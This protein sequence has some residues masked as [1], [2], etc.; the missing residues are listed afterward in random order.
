MNANPQGHNHI[1]KPLMDKFENNSENHIKDN[2]KD[3]TGT[4]CAPNTSIHKWLT[5][6]YKLTENL[7]RLLTKYDNEMEIGFK[8]YT[9][10]KLLGQRQ[11]VPM[12]QNVRK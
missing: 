9:L 2:T 1:I 3:K 11:C 6:N 5:I 10:T 12:S 4:E 7:V 8:P